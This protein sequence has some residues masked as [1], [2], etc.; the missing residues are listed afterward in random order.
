MLE[1]EST[2]ESGYSE[3]TR[4]DVRSMIR[5]ALGE[6]TE[7]R[8]GRLIDD[9]C[10]KIVLACFEEAH[11]RAKRKFYTPVFGV[12]EQVAVKDIFI[13]GASELHDDKTYRLVESHDLTQGFPPTYQIVKLFGVSSSLYKVTCQE[14]CHQ[15]SIA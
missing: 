13:T 2:I 4:V 11:E 12:K 3:P 10:K 5:E 15:C 6:Q 14:A 1:N 7:K 8:L 9:G